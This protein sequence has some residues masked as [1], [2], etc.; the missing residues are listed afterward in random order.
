MR[1][2]WNEI[3]MFC[4]PGKHCPKG[5]G[6]TEAAWAKAYYEK[7][8]LPLL[9][10]HQSVW[11]LPGLYGPNGTHA[12]STAMAVTDSDLVA[13]LSAFWAWAGTEPRITGAIPWHW[14]DL[15]P[16][17]RPAS[18]RWGGDSYPKALAWISAKVAQLP[19]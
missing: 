9:K 15:H 16:K 13:K 8:F 17:F 3:G 14:G 18:Q 19:R 10:P 11:M 12:N 7:Y 6:A 1:T 5:S 4:P 2:D